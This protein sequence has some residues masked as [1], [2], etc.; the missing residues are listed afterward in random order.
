MF[1]DL[2]GSDEQRA[3]VSFPEKSAARTALTLDGANLGQMKI[4]VK[5]LSAS[6]LQD[7]TLQQPLPSHTLSALADTAYSLS[8]DMTGHGQ[9]H[10][11][12]DINRS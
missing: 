11:N 10:A 3:F 4:R 5:M 6:A 8:S 7:Y 9:A 12:I 2:R 1:D